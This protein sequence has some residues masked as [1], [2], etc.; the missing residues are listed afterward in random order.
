[1]LSVPFPE[2]DS[3]VQPAFCL[4]S[5]SKTKTVSESRIQM[6]FCIGA[7]GF[8]MIRTSFHDTPVCNACLG[9][10]SG[11]IGPQFTGVIVDRFQSYQYAY[12][13]CFV[14]LLLFTFFVYRLPRKKQSS[15]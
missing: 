2:G 3:V 1:M 7:K 11:I 8:Q 15:K 6:K 9:L 10:L 5:N 4:C 14:Y 12:A 13:V